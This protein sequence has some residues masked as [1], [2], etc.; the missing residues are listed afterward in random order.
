MPLST[1]LTPSAAPVEAPRPSKRMTTEE[2]C[3]LYLPVVRSWAL[4]DA[5][6]L[7]V[8]LEIAEHARFWLLV[9]Q[10]YPHAAPP[11]PIQEQAA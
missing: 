10:R 2:Y 3:R 8:L 4:S 1:E 6:V 7:Q 5:E 11:A 9:D